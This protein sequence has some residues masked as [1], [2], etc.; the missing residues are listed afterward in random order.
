MG[1]LEKTAADKFRDEFFYRAFAQGGEYLDPRRLLQQLIATILRTK[2][3]T[4]SGI[5]LSPRDARS[6]GLWQVHQS[7]N[8]TQDD[9][10]GA[11]AEMQVRTRI[12]VGHRILCQV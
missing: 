12:G 5:C 9:G 7:N 2:Q 11:C 6:L 4:R 3:S 1:P 10:L 8:N